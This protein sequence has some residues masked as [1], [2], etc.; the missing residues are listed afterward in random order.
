MHLD[1]LGRDVKAFPAVE[2]PAAVRS[3]K[4]WDCKFSASPVREF[5]NLEGLEVFSLRDASLGFLADLE[6]LR[7]LSIIHMPKVA[8]LE[9]LR[10][11]R[12]L[13]VLRLHTLPSWDSSGK[14]TVVASI[15]PVAALSSLRHLE[16]FSVVPP[17]RSL[18]PLERCTT[19]VTARFHGFPKREVAR[20][21]AAAGLPNHFAPTPSWSR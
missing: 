9:P 17:D 19:L 4:L 6:A 16:L 5:E 11:L 3:V 13:E 1:L 7:Y 2:D 15:E 8:D 14:R 18:A 20:F 21:E 12:V 10:Q